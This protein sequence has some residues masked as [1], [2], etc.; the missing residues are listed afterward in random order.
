[1]WYE[2]PGDSPPPRANAD[3][4]YYRGSLDSAANSSVIDLLREREALTPDSTKIVFIMVGD[5]QT[6]RLST[7]VRLSRFLAWRG[8]DV[9]VFEIPDMEQDINT[10]VDGILQWMMSGIGV[11]FI[12]VIPEEFPHARHGDV[13]R[14]GPSRK[15][16]EIN[17]FSET[18]KVSSKHSFLKIYNGMDKVRKKKKKKKK[19]HNQIHTAVPNGD[20]K[21]AGCAKGHLQTHPNDK[22]LL[23]S[24]PNPNRFAEIDDDGQRFASWLS[25]FVEKRVRQLAG[26][27]NKAISKDEAP[28]LID[29]RSDGGKSKRIKI[30]ISSLSRA[31]ETASRIKWAGYV[32]QYPALNPLDK[33][34]FPGLRFWDAQKEASEEESLNFSARQI[35]CGVD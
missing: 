18:V 35:I 8:A 26:G 30:M 34:L 17:P 7:A 24:P 1:M 6:A 21:A 9:E 29:G 10:A 16:N 13:L 20:V 27:D 32:E 3:E 31:L 12:E 28:R 5:D 22:K 11:V 4:S 19:S 14:G 2:G 33:G 23:I 25:T 15:S